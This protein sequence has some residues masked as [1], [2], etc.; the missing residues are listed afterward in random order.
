MDNTEQK[1]EDVSIVSTRYV[2][3]CQLEIKKSK[4]EKE[5]RDMKIMKF[6]DLRRIEKPFTRFSFDFGARSFSTGLCRK[7]LLNDSSVVNSTNLRAW[8]VA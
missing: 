2:Q 8:F 3:L 7:P 5:R 4:K 6:V 1:L